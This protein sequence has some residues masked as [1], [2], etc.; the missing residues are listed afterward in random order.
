MN[1]KLE[2]LENNVA[3]LEIEVEAEKFEEG[4]QKAYIKNKNMF[5]VPGFRKGKVPRKIVE[6]YYGEEIFY[7]DAINV[8]CPDAYNEA[9]KQLSLDPVDRPELDIK[10]IGNNENFVFT[11]KVPVKPEFDLVD[12]KGI[13][14]NKIE[15]NV[16]DDEVE[17]DLKNM[18]EQSSRLVTVEDRPVQ[19]G[20]VVQIDFE[21]LINH[22]AFDGGKGEDYDLEIGSGQ[23]IPGF[24]EQ[25]IGK[26]SG[27]EVQV[28]VTF[29]ED[30]NVEKLAGQPAIFNVKIKQIRYK[31]MPEINDEFVKDVSEFD[32]LDE[33]KEDIRKRLTKEAEAK[34]KREIENAVIDKITESV[35][36]D[37]PEVMLEHQIDII[38]NNYNTSL[39]M[40][41]M[42]L[43]SYLEYSGMEMSM[44]REQHKEQAKAQV[45]TNL[46]LEKVSKLEKVEV[47][48]EDVEKNITEMAERYNMEVDKVKT[49]LRPEDIEAIKDNLITQKTIDLLVQSAKVI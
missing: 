48:D 40:Q 43:Q 7:E 34:A 38:V 32:T 4:M 23:F 14:V 18:Q 31:D 46:V 2:K 3:H 20:D 28:D 10:Q 19:N 26:N 24:E 42:S 13:E 35:E 9:V 41:G 39:Q 12:Y 29:P 37:V 17:Q 49:M 36:L 30:Y 15:Y 8:V 21:G 5:S 33:L 27:D 44:F 45:K 16:T 47:T 11:V 6:R 22:E 1:A 25:L